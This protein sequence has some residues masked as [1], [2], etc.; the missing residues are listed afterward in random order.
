MI[1]NRFKTL[2]FAADSERVS[3][4]AEILRRRNR[5]YSR[6]SPAI[7]GIWRAD[8]SRFARSENS[9]FD[10]HREARLQ[11]TIESR[12]LT[13]SPSYDGEP[14]QTTVDAAN[15]DDAITKF[16]RQSASELVSLTTPVTGNESIA[17]VRK[18]DAVFLV[19][20]YTG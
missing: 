14:K 11:Y 3:A 18:N 2:P 20:V 7:L 6:V 13:A 10:A 19:R 1:A 4:G 5:K 9:Q 8:C 12:P 17:T 16:L 15:A